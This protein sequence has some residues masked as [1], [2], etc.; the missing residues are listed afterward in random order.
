MKVYDEMIKMYLLTPLILI[1]FHEGHFL[2]LNGVFLILF[3]K[4]PLN[5]RIERVEL[6]AL[7]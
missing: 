6:T 5:H 1:L 3:L 4:I 7:D 2:R